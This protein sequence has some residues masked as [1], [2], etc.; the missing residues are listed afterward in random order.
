MASCGVYH[1]NGL[2]SGLAILRTGTPCIPLIGIGLNGEN[3]PCLDLEI[4]FEFASIIVC[5]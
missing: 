1:V 2:Q 3:V 4:N 5:V